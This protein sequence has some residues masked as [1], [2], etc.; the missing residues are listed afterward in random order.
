VHFIRSMHGHCKKGQR[1]MVAAALREVFNAEGLEDAKER[2]TS[3]IERLSGSVPKVAA[4]LAEAEEDLL[5]FYRFPAA[6]W[7]KLRSTNNIERVNK[8]IAR[9]SDVVGIFPNDR[10]VIRLVGALLIEQ[11]DEWLLTRS[12]L[13]QESIGLVLEDKADE[14]G[15]EVAALER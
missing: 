14:S 8:E 4:L 13:S 9:R 11:N 12:Y 1:N 5:A 15:S 10:S 6:H 7:S 2:A 3:V